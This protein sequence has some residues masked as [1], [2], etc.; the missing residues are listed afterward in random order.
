MISF[1]EFKAQTHE[2]YNRIPLVMELLADM[3]TPLSVYLKLANQPFTYLLESVVGGERFGRYSFIGLPCENYLTVRGNTISHFSQQKCTQQL[4]QRNPLTYIQDYLGTFK[5]PEIPDLPRFTGGLA[6]YFGYEIA[7][8]FE[9]KL[10]KHTKNDPIDTPDICLMLSEELAVIDNLSGK[11]YLIVSVN[12]E[13]EDAYFSAR[14]RLED[15]RL[16]LKQNTTIP[17]SLGSAKSEPISEYGQQAF[18]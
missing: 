11:I 16:Q 13:K 18:E 1:A 15:L 9:S 6:G 14:N 17:L 8:Y 5:T 7:H 2:G 3:D 4:E 10:G 12:P